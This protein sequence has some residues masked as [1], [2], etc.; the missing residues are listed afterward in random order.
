MDQSNIQQQ[1]A[2][3]I[4]L[5][6]TSKIE[7]VQKTGHKYDDNGVCTVC[8]H[9]KPVI[10]LKAKKAVY[11]GKAISIDEPTSHRGRSCKT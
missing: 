1:S 11:T 5:I 6:Q 10:T 9:K 3:M 8:G 2:L 7:T 4:K